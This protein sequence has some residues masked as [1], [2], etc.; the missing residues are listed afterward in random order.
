M[1]GTVCEAA[2]SLVHSMLPREE[3]EAVLC[4][5]VNVLLTN[6]KAD[7][8][9]KSILCILYPVCYVYMCAYVC[10]YAYVVQ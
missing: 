1:K 5:I 10:A 8:D 4:Q 3:A 6:A 9:W 7:V 2:I